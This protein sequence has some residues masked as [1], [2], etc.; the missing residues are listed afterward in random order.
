MFEY[1]LEDAQGYKGGEE[2]EKS[3]QTKRQDAK[4]RGDVGRLL[5]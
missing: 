3:I 5:R 1:M 2:E 4:I